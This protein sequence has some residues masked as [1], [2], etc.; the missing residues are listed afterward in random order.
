MTNLTKAHQE[1]F[2]RTPD[3]TFATLSDL[4]THCRS[5]RDSSRELWQQPQS[6]EPTTSEGVIQVTLEDGSRNRLNDWSFTQLCRMASVSKETVNRLS[7]ETACKA[8]RETLPGS[9]KPMQCLQ[10]DGIVRSLH[11]ISYTRLW[12]ADLLGVIDE[13]ATDFQPPQTAV[14]GG[15]GLY[16][17][18]QDM[19]VFL[20]DPTGWAEIEGEAFA[21]GFFL[22]NSEVGRRSL[23]IQTF[24]FQSVCANHLVWDA[25][26]VVDF[27]RK[28]T[29]KVHDGL[30]EI[31]RIIE[32]LANKRD[33]RRDSFVRVLSKAMTE[34]L[35]DDADQVLKELSKRGIPRGLAK[36]A[37]EIAEER[38]AFTIFAVVDALTRLTQK[39]TYAGDRAEADAKVASL[40]ALAI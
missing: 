37:L 20:I 1:L 4:R 32:S 12:N 24:W 5:L 21:P 8:F 19:F 2:R 9:A 6:L 25:V 14:G 23:G 33:E 13:F 27:S 7:A 11:G 26:E 18:E 28:H 30:G 36:T 15:T 35:G 3:E 17:G 34:K 22:W 39:A 29:A 16:C 38:G 31:R 40:L 10:Q